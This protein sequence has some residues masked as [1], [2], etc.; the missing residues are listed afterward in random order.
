M[1]MGGH[2]DSDDIS[3]VAPGVLPYAIDV[4]CHARHSPGLQV[5]G[6]IMTAR[7]RRRPS[8]AITGQGLS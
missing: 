6:A 7:T 3:G 4:T 2:G 1:P 8:R 5:E